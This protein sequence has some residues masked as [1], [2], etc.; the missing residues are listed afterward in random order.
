MDLDNLYELKH[1]R[2]T[3]PST[4]NLSINLEQGH[5]H[6]QEHQHENGALTGNIIMEL[7]RQQGSETQQGGTSTWKWSINKEL[8]E[9]GTSTWNWDSNMELEH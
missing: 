8:D 1:R 6:E 4:W 7:E 3:G 2:R 9:T 5:Q